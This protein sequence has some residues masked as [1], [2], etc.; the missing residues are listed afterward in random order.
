M[1]DGTKKEP[2]VGER[3]IQVDFHGETKA[4]HMCV[5]CVYN[6][7]PIPRDINSR[8]RQGRVRSGKMRQRN[9]ILCLLL[10]SPKLLF[11]P[12]VFRVSS[13]LRDVKIESR[14][15]SYLLEFS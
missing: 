4:A 5:S 14:D 15:G 11:F 9:R 7:Q 8:H 3:G 12:M 1:Q 10:W 13:G 2:G 6:Y